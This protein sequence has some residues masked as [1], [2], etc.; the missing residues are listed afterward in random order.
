MFGLAG[1][2]LGRL[3]CSAIEHPAV[4]VPVQELQRQGFEVAWTPVDAD[5][6]IDRDAFAAQVREGDRAPA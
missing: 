6:V 2:P 1:R 5:G 4:R 3:V